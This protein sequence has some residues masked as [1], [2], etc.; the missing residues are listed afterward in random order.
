M[1][2][3]PDA[4]LWIVHGDGDNHGE[5]G[6]ETYGAIHDDAPGCHRGLWPPLEDSSN[7]NIQR[8]AEVQC[9]FPDVVEAR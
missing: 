8:S 9:P 2:L 5:T 4:H 7:L 1:S 6:V 3:V